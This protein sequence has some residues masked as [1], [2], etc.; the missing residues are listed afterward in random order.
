MGTFVRGSSVW[1]PGTVVVPMMIGLSC[2]EAESA[3]RRRLLIRCIAV[4][5]QSY[6]LLV[7]LEALPHIELCRSGLGSHDGFK[8]HSD[9]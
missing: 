2:T 6:V 9:R 5:K 1:I 7:A 3:K 8:L 4:S